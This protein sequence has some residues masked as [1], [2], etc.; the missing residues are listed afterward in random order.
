MKIKKIPVEIDWICDEFSNCPPLIESSIESII[1]VARSRGLKVT[2]NDE[3]G[4][5][6]H[7]TIRNILKSQMYIGNMVQHTHEKIS[8]NN[9]NVEKLKIQNTS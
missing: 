5:W 2:E 9:K 4:I 3:C 6:K 1:S 7:S 8:Y